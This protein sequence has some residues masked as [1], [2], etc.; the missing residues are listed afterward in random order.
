MARKS[1]NFNVSEATYAL[2]K[3]I[4][5]EVIGTDDNMRQLVEA[6]HYKEEHPEQDE[7]EQGVYI[8]ALQDD[9]K[10][11]EQQLSDMQDQLTSAN[12]LNEAYESNIA[13]LQQQLATANE[14]NKINEDALN[15]LHTQLQNAHA[16]NINGESNLL[17]A[18]QPFTADLLQETARRL[19]EKYNREVTPLMVLVDMF[20]RYTIERNAEWFYPFVLTNADIITIAH[21]HNEKITSIAQIRKALN[22]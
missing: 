8:Q 15:S 11:L 22:I 19:S 1:I 12:N 13:D 16:E 4:F 9:K 7:Q 20:L 6:F 3:D 14:S 21:D 17:K 5:P 18:L 10:Q 2:V